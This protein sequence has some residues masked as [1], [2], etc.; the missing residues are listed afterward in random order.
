M[1][2]ARIVAIAGLSLVLNSCTLGPK[3]ARPEAEAPQAFKEEL[4]P[5][6]DRARPD[7]AESR[8]AWWKIYGDP[9]LNALEDQVDISN[10]NVLAAEA[11]F[12]AAKAAVPLA[13]S[14]EF[15]NVT[16][17]VS[18][19]RSGVAGSASTT[20]SNSSLD[21]NA[22]YEADMWSAIRR[23]VSAN[24]DIAQASAAEAEN[25][26]LLFRAEVAV[27]YFQLQGIDAERE[28]LA[29]A[30]KS[31]EQNV[32]LTQ[33]RFNG[34]VASMGDVALA[35][36]QLETA[37]GQLTDLEVQRAQFEHAIAVLIGKAPSEVSIRSVS[38]PASPPP[39]SVGLPSTLLERRPD[40]AEAERSVAAANEGIGIAKSALYPLLTWSGVAGSQT[41]SISRLLSWPTRFWSVGPEALQTLFDAGK[42]RAELKASQANYD[43]TVANYRQTVLTALQQVEDSLAQLRIL[44]QEEDI[45]DRAVKAAEESLN[46]STI[47]YRS[48]STSYLQ[49]IDSQTSVLQNQ[50]SAA[51]ILTRRLVASVDLIQALGGGWDANQIK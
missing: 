41:S 15:P 40:I 29:A 5:G 36:T 20:H 10:Q 28:L 39:V 4:P 34:G 12:R 13:R 45:V 24:K 32:Q 3:Y 33:D 1:N 37:R 46:V 25:A 30:V 44:G 31:Y 26:S 14:E 50:R 2:R 27:D 17:A 6:W 51:N 21:I 19:T 47:Q 8:G 16:A 38:M 42:R 49:V 23:S 11:R 18:S 48:G 7:D 22:T 35:Q 43:A 9:Q